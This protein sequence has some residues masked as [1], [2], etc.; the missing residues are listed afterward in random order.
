MSQHSRTKRISYRIF[1]VFVLLIAVHWNV[2]APPLVQAQSSFYWPKQG[3]PEPPPS[4]LYSVT[5]IEMPNGDATLAGWV[6]EPTRVEPVDT[7]VYCHGNAGNME[8]HV[9]FMDFLPARGFRVVMFDYQGYGD[10]SPN[11]PT[12]ESTA[13]DVNAAIDFA[14]GRWGKPW[15]MG[16][17]LGASLAIAVAGQRPRD[18]RGVVAVAP[19]TSYGAMARTVLRRS[20]LTRPLVLPSYA[21]VR[22]GYDPIDVVARIAPTPILLVHGEQD[23]L[24]PPRMSRELFER[25]SSPKAL[26]LLPDAGHN[27][28]WKEMGPRYADTIV[29]FLRGDKNQND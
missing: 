22:S 28:T 27:S 1:R 19:F 18:L 20:L 5:R 7:V 12:R 24:I 3:T 17:S 21:I 9:A 8:S 4:K 23:E 6:F 2:A 14:M 25:A 13:S 10:S 16:Q 11:K 29:R 26:L 15:I